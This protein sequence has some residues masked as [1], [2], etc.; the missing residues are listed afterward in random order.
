MTIYVLVLDGVFDIGLASLL[1][2]IGMA[3]ELAIDGKSASLKIKSSMVAVSRNVFTAHGLRVPVMLPNSLPPPDVV[4]IPAIGSK[5]PQT[6]LSALERDDVQRMGI[7]IKNG[8]G[9]VH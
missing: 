3:Q 7:W 6:L 1:D 5:T 8:P 2:V 4:L 9:L